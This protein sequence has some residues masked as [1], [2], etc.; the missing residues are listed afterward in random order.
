MKVVN[1]EDNTTITPTPKHKMVN[2]ADDKHNSVNFKSAKKLRLMLKAGAPLGDVQQKAKLEG[3][4][5]AIVLSSS[6]DENKVNNE[7]TM[8]PEILIKKYKR[9]LKAG[10]T[11]DRVQQLASIETGASPEEVEFIVTADPPAVVGGADI[12]EEVAHQKRMTKF[13]RM[14]RAGI[15]VIAIANAAR[16][17]GFDVDEVTAALE[18]GSGSDSSSPVNVVVEDVNENADQNLTAIDGTAEEMTG[19]I[20][21]T[22]EK[23]ASIRSHFTLLDGEKYLTERKWHFHQLV[24]VTSLIW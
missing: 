19:K 4:D 17:Q 12:S 9:M 16:L 14:Q 11:M 1:K 8:I 20:H 15:P 7:L 23:I 5:M 21:V 13:L 22:N 10:I 3:V 24:V 18:G 2:Y 6:S